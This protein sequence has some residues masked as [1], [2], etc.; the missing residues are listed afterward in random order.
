MSVEDIKS[1]IDYSEESWQIV[2]SARK[3]LDELERA[4]DEVERL[5]EENKRLRMT[6]QALADLA[7]QENP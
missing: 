3:T 2:K 6:E 5:R 7:S 1:C 4:A